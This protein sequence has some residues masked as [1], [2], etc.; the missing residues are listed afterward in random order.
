MRLTKLKRKILLLLLE[1]RA[2]NVEQLSLMIYPNKKVTIQEQIKKAAKFLS[3]ETPERARIWQMLIIDSLN[4][5][6]KDYWLS[7]SATT[8][9]RRALESMRK[10]GLIIKD[11]FFEAND[12]REY[13]LRYKYWHW[14]PCLTE[15]GVEVAKEIK[16]EIAEYIEEWSP[17]LKR[18]EGT[19]REAQAV[20][21]A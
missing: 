8:S 13:Q 15:K 14:F 5:R 18:P 21:K 6:K 1:E 16:R 12:E 9:I 20:Q 10:E 11:D 17:F 7:K 19:R 2:H 4:R 3:K